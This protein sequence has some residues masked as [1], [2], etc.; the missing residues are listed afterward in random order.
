MAKFSFMFGLVQFC[1]SLF[2]AFNQ[3]LLSRAL[4]TFSWQE[5]FN[6]IGGFGIVLL[7]IAGFYLRD[8]MPVAVPAGQTFATSLRSVLQSVLK[9]ARLPHIW[10]AATF[11]G[12]CF[13]AMLGLGIVWAPKLLTARGLDADLA[14]MAS[15]FLWLGLAV[16][17]FIIPWSSDRL[18]RRKL[19]S[20]IGIGISLV[21]L[22]LLLYAPSQG[23]AFDMALCFLF[24]FGNAAHMLAFSTAGDV[25]KPENIGTSAAIVNGTMFIIGGIMISRPGMRIGLGLDAGISPGTLEAAQFVARPL[26]VGLCV[27]FIVAALMRETY[28]AKGMQ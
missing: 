22:A 12:F 9:I 11:G 3:N 7:I 2:S 8:P 15:S 21:A 27:A 25:V 10:M 20:I 14:N 6:Y 19:P 1:A 26:L 16:G 4:A 17:C 23:A 24:G 5:L 13:G 18:R 28:P